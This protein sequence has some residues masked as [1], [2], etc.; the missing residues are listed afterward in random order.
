MRARAHSSVLNSTQSYREEGKT[1][2]DAAVADA[3]GKKRATYNRMRKVY[4]TA[5]DEDAPAPVR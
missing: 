3:V 1:R 4:E 2:T 5:K